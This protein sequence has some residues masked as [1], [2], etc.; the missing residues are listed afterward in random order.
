MGQTPDWD[1]KEL[2]ETAAALIQ[3]DRVRHK[4]ED[5]R[6]LVACALADIIRIY[7]PDAPYDDDALKV[8][9]F[10]L[11]PSLEGVVRCVTLVLLQE[12]F[13]LFI[14]QMA[15]LGQTDDAAHSLRFY[16]MERLQSVGAFALLIDLDEQLYMRLYDTFFEVVSY[17]PASRRS[18]LTAVS[19]LPLTSA[20][21]RE[22]TQGEVVNQML[23]I[24]SG[25]FEESDEITQ[26][27][28]EKILSNLLPEPKVR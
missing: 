16:L 20:A 10:C 19:R 12:I 7:A 15:S 6:L 25:C 9:Y 28:L 21:Y 3:K 2:D 23:D 27:L 14:D 8:F 26:E 24:M 17:V 4:S 18:R 13:E 5:V 11:L 22:N 1:K